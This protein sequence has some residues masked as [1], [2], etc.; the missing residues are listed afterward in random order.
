MSISLGPLNIT[1][2]IYGVAVAV[3][4]TISVIGE[5][6]FILAALQILPHGVNAISQL[7]LGGMIGSG[8]AVSILIPLVL[9]L[10]L[11]RNKSEE[12]SRATY[13]S[14]QFTDLEQPNVVQESESAFTAT[15]EF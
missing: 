1:P 14:Q 15:G 9:L 5:L 13:T 8:I 10:N 4:T 12:I 7:S 2:K 6:F 11:C 3:I